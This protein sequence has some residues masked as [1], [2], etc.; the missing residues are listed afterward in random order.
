[1][2]PLMFLVA[3]SLVAVTVACGERDMEDTAASTT[4]QTRSSEGDISFR[5]TP[6]AWT[7]G[8]LVFDVL[9]DTHSGDLA[10]VRLRDV[11]KLQVGS[12]VY[13]PV[14]AT[15]LAGHHA[16]GSVTFEVAEAPTRFA[17][18]VTGVRSMSAL[19]FDWP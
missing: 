8:R 4:Y 10:E 5:F 11:V 6:Q 13:L 3:L 2:K 17:V 1:M 9:A 7:S 19:S 12:Q 15:S 18:T 16:E 14:E